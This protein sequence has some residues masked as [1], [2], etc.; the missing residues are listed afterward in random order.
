[1]SLISH[2]NADAVKENFIF[3]EW[4]APANIRSI[5]TTR[6]GGVS[7][8]H[9]ESF[10]IAQHVED[11]VRAVENNRTILR[12]LLPNEPTW[13]RQV[14]GNKVIHA[15]LDTPQN[16]E[17]DAAVTKTPGVVLAIQTADCLPVLFS[18]RKGTIV[19]AC[20]AGWR[21]LCNGVVEHTMVEMQCSPQDIIVYLGPA[22]GPKKFEVGAEVRE[23]FIGKHTKTAS[24]FV[25]IS[26]DKWLADIYSLARIRLS[27]AGVTEIYGGNFC[28][29]SDHERFYSYRRHKQTG[30]MASLIWLTS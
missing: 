22:I 18:D 8:D 1:M 10:N 15:N 16:M 4:P 21:G 23:A 26:D 3:P 9:F 14:H 12:R 2:S 29:F 28:T 20:H 11:N 13:L 24:A 30:R 6:K 25:Q 5:I 7:K 17:A 19:G 27:I